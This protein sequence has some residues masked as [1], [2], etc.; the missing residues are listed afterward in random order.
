MQVPAGRAGQS[1]ACK[2]HHR[3]HCKNE[4]YTHANERQALQLRLNIS[5]E[6]RVDTLDGLAGAFGRVKN[7]I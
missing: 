4:K 5:I 6:D 1:V 2:F 3:Q 7:T